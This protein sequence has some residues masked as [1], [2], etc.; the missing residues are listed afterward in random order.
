ME[1]SIWKF[2][3]INMTRAGQYRLEIAV[4]RQMGITS[5]QTSDAQRLKINSVRHGQMYPQQSIVTDTC[6]KSDDIYL[7][8]VFKIQFERQ[9]VELFDVL[10]LDSPVQCDHQSAVQ[11][12]AR[13]FKRR[14]RFAND[15]EYLDFQFYSVGRCNK[16]LMI[17]NAPSYLELDFEE[18]GYM[19]KVCIKMCPSNLVPSGDDS[20]YVGEL[21]QCKLLEQQYRISNLQSILEES[22]KDQDSIKYKIRQNGEPVQPVTIG[23]L[24][25][26]SALRTS[27]QKRVSGSHLIVMVHGLWGNSND[28]RLYRNLMSQ[29][30]EPFQTIQQ[31]DCVYLMSKTN[32]EDPL[33]SLELMGSR[34]AQEVVDFITNNLLLVNKLSFVCHSMGGLVVRVA[35]ESEVLEQYKDCLYQMR[36][37]GSPHLGMVGLQNQSL[38]M[39]S[40]LAKLR[41]MGVITGSNCC[42]DQLWMRDHADLRQS[43]IYKLSSSASLSRFHQVVCVGSSQ[44]NYVPYHSAL[45]QHSKKGQSTQSHVEEVLKEMHH[46]LACDIRNLIQIDLDFPLNTLNA[47]GC[48][49]KLDYILG[50]SAHILPLQDSKCITLVQALLCYHI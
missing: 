26:Q 21:A 28:F 48:C 45:I 5:D 36:T 35:V 9:I 42:L 49:S 32:S 23:C 1:L 3:N 44:D 14:G 18:V 38:S 27:E 50:R 37:F 4:D 31:K 22:R 12:R 25:N 34:L 7:T 33:Q 8:N 2:Q 17:E 46:N 29:I 10:Q 16:T 41:Y 40:Q 11:V 24:L 15:L 30:A 47:P 20:V 6:V 19:S 13:L 43:F 39:L